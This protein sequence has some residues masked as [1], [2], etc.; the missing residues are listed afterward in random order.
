MKKRD[1]VKSNIL[2]NDIINKGKRISNKYFLICYLEKDFIKNNYGIAVGKKIGN[3]VTR[4]KIKRQLR[5]LIDIYKNLFPSN[6]NYIIIIKKD[7]LVS[8]FKIKKEE[9]EKLLG[10]VNNEK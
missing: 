8:D 7:Y 5:S 6:Y 1:I 2:F 10:K 9:F 3:A 4:N